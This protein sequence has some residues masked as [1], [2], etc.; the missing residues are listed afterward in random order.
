MP[1]VL[2]GD[3]RG[4]DAELP[5][6]S[7]ASLVRGEVELAAVPG[8]VVNL[9]GLAFDGPVEV[10]SA[11]LAVRQPHGVL[12]Q[13]PGQPGGDDG[14]L[15]HELQ[16]GVDRLQPGRATL[17]HPPE[18]RRGG[19]ERRDGGQLLVEHLLDDRLQLFVADDARQIEHRSRW[20]GE[21]DP[22]GLFDDVDWV[23]PM[24]PVDHDAGQSPMVLSGDDHVQP[25]IP[26]KPT[27]APPFP[28]R[29]MGDD[30]VRPSRAG[31]GGGL[32]GGAGRASEAVDA[33]DVG[34]QEALPTKQL[35]ALAADAE[36]FEVGERDDAM[37]DR[38]PVG[39]RRAE[40]AHA[41]PPE[42]TTPGEGGRRYPSRR[43]R[44]S[45]YVSGNYPAKNGSVRAAGFGGWC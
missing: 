41:S 24:G 17:D 27:K 5:Y 30:D 1:R 8:D 42:E 28:G 7:I 2:V 45:M 39:E 19:M 4:V 13:R 23:E 9:Q 15:D 37:A 10:Q 12:A 43:S 26:A 18:P 34:T 6:E 44:Q 22:V 14:P 36:P 33:G 38:Q 25:I 11:L 31:E 21:P 16:V 40:T 3:A 20:A 32:L 29:N 35:T